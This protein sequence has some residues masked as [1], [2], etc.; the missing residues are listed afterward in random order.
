MAGCALCVVPLA[1]DFSGTPGTG[2]VLLQQRKRHACEHG[3]DAVAVKLDV[4]ARELRFQVVSLATEKLGQLGA[5]E[6]SLGCPPAL[7]LSV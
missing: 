5:I 7:A 2:L 4:A 1:S 3:A 6:H